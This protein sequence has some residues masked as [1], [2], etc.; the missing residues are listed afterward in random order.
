MYVAGLRQAG[1]QVVAVSDRFGDAGRAVAREAGCPFYLDVREALDAARPDFAIAFGRHAEMPEVVRAVLER[2]V[3]SLLEK[4]LGLNAEQVRPLAALAEATGAYAGVSFPR[5]LS[6][7]MARVHEAH[8][9]GRLRDLAHGHFRIVNGYP[10]RYPQWGNAWMLDPALSGGGP[11]RNLGIHGL[12]QFRLL[13]DLVGAGPIEVVWAATTA[14]LYRGP[15]EDWAVVALRAGDFT[16]TVEA[17]YTYPTDA[18]GGDSEWRLAARDLYLLETGHTLLVRTG[19]DL[20][21]VSLATAPQGT[22][23]GYPAFVVDALARFAAGRPPAATIADCLAAVE[24]VDRA[25]ARA[26]SPAA[27]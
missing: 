21:T 25:Y 17:G 20:E 22:A 11:L 12:D 15:I 24:L 23:H 26:G 10:S 2:R 14:S 13:A 7:F 6:A 1:A 8:A 5:R 3:P 18:P 27:T 19:A 9:A 16:A 4:P